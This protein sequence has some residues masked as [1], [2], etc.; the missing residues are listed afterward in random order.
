[1]GGE[2]FPHRASR[3][4]SAGREEE[5]FDI[6]RILKILAEKGIAIAQETRRSNE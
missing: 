3:R 6:H 5:D 4:G 2:D 1:M